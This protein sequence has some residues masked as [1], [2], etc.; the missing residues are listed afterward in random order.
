MAAKKKKTAPKRTFTVVETK[1][2]RGVV[3]KGR[4][5]LGGVYK[6]SRPSSAAKKAASKKLGKQQGI[7]IK[8]MEITRGGKG[9]TYA[10]HVTREKVDR[11]VQRGDAEIVYKYAL[12]ARSIVKK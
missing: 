2:S 10:Y 5:N 3:V 11:K 4:E 9:K 7:D 6:A 8:I 12:T 1:T